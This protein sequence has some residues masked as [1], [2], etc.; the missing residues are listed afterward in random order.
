MHANALA[1]GTVAVE[2]HFS[3]SPD[4][5]AVILSGKGVVGISMGGQDASCMTFI[6]SYS[7]DDCLFP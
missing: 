2:T 7:I 3:A 6:S 4:K 5:E 1:A